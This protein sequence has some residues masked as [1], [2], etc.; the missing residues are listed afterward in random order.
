M[1]HI[2]VADDNKTTTRTLCTLVERWGH[3]AYPAFDGA[4]AL[5]ILKNEPIDIVVTDLKMPHIDGI[6]LLARVRE[7]WPDIVV[8]VVTAFGSIETAV[9]AMKLGAFDFLTK[10]YENQELQLKLQKAYEKRT[11]VLRLERLH[12]RVASF[13]AEAEQQSGMGEIIGS[14]P[15][16]QQIF[17]NIRKV[18]PTDSTVLLL[19]ESGTGK[20]MAARAIHAQ[21]PRKDAPFI[22]VHCAAYSEGLLESELFGHERGAFTGAIERKIGRFEQADKGTLF[23]DEIGGISPSTQIK[24]LRFLQEREFER[25]GGTKTLHFDLRII[26][27]TNRDLIG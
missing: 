15:A 10:P 5:Q 16:M 2:L 7:S 14:S 4:E 26:A 25:V 6:E 19:G 13:E 11:M 1:I 22:P 24:L 18:A 20:E 27:A 3:K 23:L 12:A 9:E 8:I 17:K 21:S